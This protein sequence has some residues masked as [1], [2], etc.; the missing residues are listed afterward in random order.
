M[1]DREYF[2]YGVETGKSNYQNYRW[3]PELTIPMAMI[4]IDL[5]G[6][7]PNESVLDY[8]CAKGYLVKALRM[9]H[10]N[11]WGTDISDYALSKAEEDTKPYLFKPDEMLNNKL[12]FKFCIGKDVFEH[13]QEEKLKE[14]LKTLNVE[15]LFAIIPL[16]EN[17]KYIAPANNMD[18]THIICQP[19]I[20]WINLF[21]SCGWNNIYTSMKVLGIKDSYYQLYP[22]SHL[23]GIYRRMK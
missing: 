20:W 17:G 19:K 21:N 18:K 14:I 11:A 13:I 4:I 23:F 22:E 1:Y 9:L 2:E 16:G 12:S 5:L 3:I 8:G 15:V 10:R 6:I 7:K